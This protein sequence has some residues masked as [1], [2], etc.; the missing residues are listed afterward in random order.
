MV[1]NPVSLKDIM[2]LVERTRSREMNF[3]IPWQ[4]YDFLMTLTLG[5]WEKICIDAFEVI[6]K[7]FKNIIKETSQLI[8]YRFQTSGLASAAEYLPVETLHLIK[9]RRSAALDIL[10][11]L[12][13]KTHYLI[14][15][16]CSWETSR[17]FTQNDDY[18]DYLRARI[19]EYMCQHRYAIVDVVPGPFSDSQNQTLRP[20][21]VGLERLFG[22]LPENAV[23][24]T[25]EELFSR[26]K[27][28][29]DGYVL[30]IVTN[31]AAYFQV[32]CK[33]VIDIVPMCIE[34]RFLMMLSRALGDKLEKDL[35]L[36]SEDAAKICAG[37]IVE[38]PDAQERW[39]KLAIM[40]ATISEGLKITGELTAVRA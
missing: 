17:P 36:L 8:F 27:Q 28:D 31:T 33:R 35:G 6:E 29:K 34:N 1:E 37:F 32:A 13:E 12:A 23:V 9:P 7:H 3:F 26:Y 4:V 11:D 18:M 2:K 14:A 25:S 40:K 5:K 20:P 19:S 10:D 24:L 22:E 38:E 39:E 16:Y 15:M 21:P 30:E